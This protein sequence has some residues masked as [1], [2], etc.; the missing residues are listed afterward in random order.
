M[1]FPLKCLQNNQFHV[2]L[3]LDEENTVATVLRCPEKVNVSRLFAPVH[4]G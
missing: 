4:L 1:D 2:T 3:F